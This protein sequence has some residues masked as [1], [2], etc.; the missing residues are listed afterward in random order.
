M[1]APPAAPADGLPPPGRWLALAAV[2]ATVTLAVLDSSIVNVALPTI[3]HDQ[4]VS[5]EKAI[6]LVTTYQLAI[7]VSLLPLA[8]LG[9]SLGFHKVYLSGVLVFGVASFLCAQAPTLEVLMFARVVQGLG[10]AAIMSLNAALVRHIVP[11]AWLARGIG[12]VAMTVAVS[13]AAGPTIAAAILSI[14][15]WHWLFYVNVPVSAV[16][17]GLGYFTLPRTVPS[18]LRFDKGSA[19]LNVLTFGPLI[20]GLEHLSGRLP[21]GVLLGLFATAI[22]SGTFL[23]R[24]QLNRSSPMLPVD[25]LARPRF[26]QAIGASVAAFSGQFL[27][28]V[29]IP[30]YFHDVLGF[31]AVKTGLLLTAWP[32][33]TGIAAPLAGRLMDRFSADRLR[34]VGL[35]LFASG[36]VLTALVGTGFDEVAKRPG[37]FV[38]TLALTGAGFGLYQAPNNHVLLTSAPRERS[39]GASGLLSTARLLGQGTGAALAATL[40]TAFQPFNLALLLGTAAGFAFLSAAI[41]SLGR[42]RASFLGPS[43]EIP[44]R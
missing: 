3:A 15:T 21:T 22:V 38:V 25:L 17:L 37:I 8:A 1:N 16:A 31:S 26:A 11:K 14:A 44:S 35:A 29:T 13:A 43:Q 18:G 23:T 10:A 12:L 41:C 27:A 20:F 34:L 7:V 33:S 4:G 6:A 24:R 9:E 28:V 19:A 40:L 32:V 5:P 39:G 36:L 30:F 42:A 2:M